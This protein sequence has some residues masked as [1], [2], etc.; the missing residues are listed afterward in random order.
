MQNWSPFYNT[1]IINQQDATLAVLYLL[2][3]TS[4]LYMFRT[5]LC[6][7]HYEHYKL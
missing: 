2:T 3:V 4:M 6:V 5:P 7:H 1:C